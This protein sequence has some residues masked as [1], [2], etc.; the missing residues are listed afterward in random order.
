MSN[1]VIID[2]DAGNIRSVRNALDRLGVDSTVSSSA[3]VIRGADRVIFPGVGHARPAL[4]RLQELELDAVIPALHQPVLGICLGMQLLCGSNEEAGF[5][6]LGVFD[7]PVKRFTADVKV[8][9]MGW[10]VLKDTSG[11]LGQDDSNYAYFV[12]S[13]YVPVFENT[14]ASVSYGNDISVA[15]EKD[16]FIG[17]QFHPE[18]SGPFGEQLIKRFM[19]WN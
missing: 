18:K 5:D 15:I 4:E 1:V 17:C 2:Y 6:G 7:V 14:I 12:H 8:P 19:T 10:N 11:F 3:E 16:N 9:H 13:Y